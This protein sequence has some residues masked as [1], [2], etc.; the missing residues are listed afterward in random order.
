VSGNAVT[1]LNVGGQAIAVAG[2]IFDEGSLTL[3]A[4]TV[5]HNRVDS[6][7]PASSHDTALAGA[8]GIEMNGAATI[9]GSRFLGN[10][11]TASAP[12]GSVGGGG[13]GISNF[14]QTTLERSV[15][16]GN[17][18]T[19][20]GGTGTVHGGGIYNDTLFGSTPT[21]SV[22]DSVVT[23]NRLAANPGVSPLGGGLF[24][25]FP[26]TLSNTIIAGN[27][28]DQCDGC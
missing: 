5:A 28:P 6:S 26:V 23:A 16:S 14:G 19:A 10:S 1:A 27:R 8:G 20:N 18:F 12:A 22:T 24:T 13:G 2:G 3:T 15:V 9:S 25:A 7:V 4:S 21:L 17:T 11:V